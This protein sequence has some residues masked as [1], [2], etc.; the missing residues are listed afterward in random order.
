[1]SA[2]EFHGF[3]AGTARA[4]V[5][6]AWYHVGINTANTGYFAK[7]SDGKEWVWSGGYFDTEAEAIGACQSHH[8]QVTP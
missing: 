5:G 4:D 7:F 2:L 8:A 6:K 3:W 1:M